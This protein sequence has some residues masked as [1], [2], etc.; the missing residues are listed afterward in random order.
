MILCGYGCGQEGKYQ[1]KN[2]KWCCSKSTSICPQMKKINS[3]LNTGREKSLYTRLLLSKSLTC[4]KKSKD[5]RKKLSVAHTGK[6][7][8]KS[9]RQ[10][11]S[12]AN[13]RKN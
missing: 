11:I 2:G 10:N 7:L 1:F 8:T 4:K 13:S 5:H 9:H 6:T 12:K 3:V